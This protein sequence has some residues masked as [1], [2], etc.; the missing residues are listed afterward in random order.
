VGRRED[1][2]SRKKIEEMGIEGD[3]GRGERGCEEEKGSGE[4][5]GV[6]E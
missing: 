1:G 2:E 3:K 4:E 6:G 5:K